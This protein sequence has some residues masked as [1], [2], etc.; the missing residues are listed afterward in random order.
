V[1]SVTR[2]TDGFTLDVVMT[3]SVRSVRVRGTVICR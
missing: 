2:T 1:G 3:D